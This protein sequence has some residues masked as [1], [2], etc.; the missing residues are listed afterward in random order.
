MKEKIKNYLKNN[1][2]NGVEI[3]FI[4]EIEDL[5][6]EVYEFF[7]ENVSD[8]FHSFKSQYQ[9]LVLDHCYLSFQAMM[10]REIVAFLKERK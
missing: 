4:E 6:K 3:D 7:K 2:P 1:Y 9:K 8:N 10:S 5:L